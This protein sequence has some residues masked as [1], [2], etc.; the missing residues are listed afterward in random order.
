MAFLAAAMIMILLVILSGLSDTMPLDRTYFLKA[1]TRGISGARSISQWTFFRICG[2]D[3]E[4]CGSAR[5]AIP[6]GYAWS[7]NARNAPEDL[8]GDRGD[9]TTSDFYFLAWRFGWVFYLIGLFFTACAFVSGVL[10]CI[11]RLGARIAGLVSIVALICYTIAVS[12]MTAVFVR[13]RNA[14]VEDDRD[15][16][17]GS[18]AFGLSWG[19]FGAIFVAIV[20]FC[21]GGRADKSQPKQGRRWIPTIPFLRGRNQSGTPAQ[22][23]KD[24]NH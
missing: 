10:A 15:A 16:E 13:A 22:Q 23:D 3:N 9:D 14:F 4:N 6:F 17:I 18:Y 8:V 24:G 12:L 2:E 19:A 7:S 1:E 5:A 20:L 11:G 21:L